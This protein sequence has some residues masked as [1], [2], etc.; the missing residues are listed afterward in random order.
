[1][2]IAL[3]VLVLV[4]TL[5]CSA[6]AQ[7]SVF[8]W[9]ENLP[10]KVVY[11]YRAVNSRSEEGLVGVQIGVDERSGREL[12]LRVLP[13]GFDDDESLI[14]SQMMGLGFPIPASSV[15]TPS[16]WTAAF[17]MSEHTGRGAIHFY[18][19]TPL[20]SGTLRGFSIDLPEPD[21]AYLNGNWVGILSRGIR[22]WG[23][24]ARDTLDAPAPTASLAGTATICRGETATL[25]VSL[26]G[27]GPW[28]LRWSDG[29]TEQSSTPS[30]NR[31]VSPTSSMR[32]SVSVSDVNREGTSAG[33]AD[34]TVMQPPAIAVPPSSVVVPKRT[35][36]TLSVTANGTNPLTYEWFEGPSGSTTIPVG[37]NS[38]TFTTPKLT[39]T[40]SYWVR[41]TN[42]CG[43]TSSQT[44]TVTVQ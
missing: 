23:S 38:S 41:V 15:G 36:V 5:S 4:A 29:F 30:V 26:T 37:G 21:S 39:R 12:Q 17:L 18:S 3:T 44:A 10:D 13:V 8:V 16:P 7:V 6:T 1:M 9:Q 20:H 35:A 14:P 40:T 25:T 22:A 34:V 42:T 28:S 32:Y 2:R 33:V 27:N 11:H 19:S 24:L 43:S 31:A